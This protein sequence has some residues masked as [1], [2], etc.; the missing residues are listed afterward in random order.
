MDAD[1]N[2]SRRIRRTPYTTKAVLAGVTGFSVVNHMLLPKSYGKSIEEDYWHLREFVQVWDV[3]CQR[4]VQIEGPDAALLI[5]KMTPRSICD[6]KVGQ[7]Y[8]ITIIDDS[9]G[10][11]NDP[12]LLKLS[13][14]KFWVSIADSDV[15]LYAKGLAIGMELNVL[16]TEPD[17]FPL[18]IQGPKSE[19]VLAKLFGDYIR[20]IG[21][22]NF[23]W[24]NFQGTEQ[25]IARSGYSSQ[26]GFE[27]YLKGKE[28]GPDLWDYIL[29]GGAFC[30]I[31]PGCPNLIDR[32]E[33]GLL[34]YGNEMTRENNP[35]ELGLQKFCSLDGSI[36]YIGLN[37]LQKIH[38]RGPTK[39]IRGVIFEGDP[40][41]ACTIPWPVFYKDCQIGR[42]TSGIYSPRLKKN[43]GLGLI[44]V[45]FSE[46]NQTVKVHL[47]N[48]VKFKGSITSLPFC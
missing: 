20:Q 12:V 33:S 14:N 43:I 40:C 3:S 17:V 41:S 15:L 1:L 48:D 26:G 24:V 45:E 4:Q 36:D 37:A 16:I 29:E 10:I 25:L 2:M 42:I 31:S 34:S 8:Y 6:L 21:F 11:I 38:K 27:I 44:D 39:I 30:N 28:M 47:P 19:D 32:V 18:A 9:G 46:L 23:G 22:F 13:E 5:Q 35:L 7:C